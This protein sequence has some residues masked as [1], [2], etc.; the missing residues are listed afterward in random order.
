VRRTSLGAEWDPGPLPRWSKEPSREADAGQ[1][2]GRTMSTTLAGPVGAGQS[3]TSATRVALAAMVIV[4]LVA[5]SFALGRITVGTQHG[6]ANPANT[7]AQTSVASCHVARP[8]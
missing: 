3:W 6:P 5:A 2:K 1:A 4:L 8:C 7:A